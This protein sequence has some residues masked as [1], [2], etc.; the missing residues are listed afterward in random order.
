MPPG[1]GNLLSLILL[2]LLVS[3]FRLF[4]DS[5]IFRISGRPHFGLTHFCSNLTERAALGYSGD[6]SLVTS[7]DCACLEGCS[8]LVLAK[9]MD[10]AGIHE[11]ET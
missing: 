3:S 8:N 10:G 4:L 6:A 11:L 5:F 7:E 9:F 1:I 2:L